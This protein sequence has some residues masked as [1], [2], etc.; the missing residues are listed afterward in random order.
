M[1]SRPF[2]LRPFSVRPSVRPFRPSVR[3]RPSVF[4]PSVRPSVHFPSVRFRPSFRPSVRVPSVRPS[5]L[6]FSVRPFS[7]RPFSVR[8]SVRSV[9]P[10][11]PSNLLTL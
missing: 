7:V 2:S 1:L 9:R 6:P 8:P 11:R 10:F 3:F 5:V 4:R